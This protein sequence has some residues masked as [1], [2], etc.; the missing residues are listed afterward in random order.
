MKQWMQTTLAI[1]ALFFIGIQLATPGDIVR[2]HVI[3]N[4]DSVQDQAVK[5]QV[6]DAILATLP[7]ENM[8]HAD[9][10]A[11]ISHHLRD[12]E[13]IAN[14]TLAGQGF[15]ADAKAT[16]GVTA[17]PARQYGTVVYPAGQ[18]TALQIT[19]GTGTG[20]NWWCVLYPPLCYDDAVSAQTPAPVKTKKTTPRFRSRIADWW[21]G[22]HKK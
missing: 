13:A 20:R 2:L 19:L 15:P 1:A 4:S 17:F 9:T 11:Y 16:Y 18:Y 12:I 21:K 14:N 7:T 3:A 10:A 6:R 5:L 8:S 22:T